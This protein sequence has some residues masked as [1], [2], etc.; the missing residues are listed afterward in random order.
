M[1]IVDAIDSSSSQSDPKR[2]VFFCEE[3]A[4]PLFFI[5]DLRLVPSERWLIPS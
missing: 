5:A 2:K 1:A 3:R 4:V